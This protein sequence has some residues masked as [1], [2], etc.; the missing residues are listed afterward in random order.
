VNNTLK[1]ALGP[2]ARSAVEANTGSDVPAGIQA[3]LDEYVRRIESGVRPIG[4]PRLASE[5]AGAASDDFLELPV[6]EHTFAVL[7]R[8][9]ALQGASPGEIAAHA[10]LLYLAELD[11]LSPPNASRAA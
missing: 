4:L 6:D 7:E 1:V 11:R 8:E 3:A 10:V 2:F 9:A 5:A